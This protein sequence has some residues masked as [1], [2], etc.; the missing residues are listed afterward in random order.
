[1]A[2]SGAIAVSRF[3]GAAHERERMRQDA[4]ARAQFGF[5]GAAHERER[6][7]ALNQLTRDCVVSFN[8]AAH[9]RERMLTTPYSLSTPMHSASMEP[10]TNV[11]GCPP[12]RSRR[13]PSTASMEPPTNVSGCRRR[14]WWLGV[15]LQWSRPRT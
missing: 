1:M 12:E 7:H 5:N 8:G 14:R 10:P 15:R 2:A 6:M 11:S 13:A 9:E 4:I 3:N